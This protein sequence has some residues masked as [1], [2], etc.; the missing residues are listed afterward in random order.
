MG[1]GGDEKCKMRAN[2]EV[3][4]KRE[5]ERERRYLKRK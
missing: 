5:R 3:A 1:K 2:G 4:R